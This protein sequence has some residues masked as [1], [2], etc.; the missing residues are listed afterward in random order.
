[1]A[2]GKNCKFQAGSGIDDGFCVSGSDREGPVITIKN[3]DPLNPVKPYT[4][5]TITI[6]TNEASKCKFNLGNAS[7]KFSNM[8]YR[9]GEGFDNR[10]TVVLNF[11][12]Q[13]YEIEGEETQYSIL[14]NGLNFTMYIRCVDISG[15]GE[16]S[17]PISIEIDVMNAPEFN[18]PLLSNFNPVSGSA[19]RYNSTLQAINFKMNEPAECRW[20]FND[21]SFEVMGNNFNCDTAPNSESI[22]NG[23]SCAGI[24]TNVTLELNNQTKYYIKCKDHPEY[25]ADNTTINGVV[26][27][28]NSHTSENDYE[29][30]L[31]PSSPLEITYVSPESTITVNA[32]NSTFALEAYTSGGAGAGT[33]VCFWKIAD[34]IEMNGTS[35]ARFS[36]TNSSRHLHIV[37]NKTSNLYYAQVRCEDVA[38]NMAWRNFSF[39]LILD[40]SGPEILRFY[41][42]AE[43][44]HIYTSEPSTC[45]IGTNREE[46]CFFNFQNATKMSGYGKEHGSSWNYNDYNY[47]ICKDYFGNENAGCAMVIRTY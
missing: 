36:R 33:S 41:N 21:T 15:N 45:A 39:N 28:R 30:I 3:Q 19:I 38:G 46:G 10:H 43:G 17:R 12:G 34:N 23:Y 37:T 40:Y 35:L 29:Y 26:Y 18:A 16:L 9:F 47:I 32:G 42:Y 14:A 31:R 20:S 8:R 6:S 24:L 27:S 22:F 1:M 5:V 11:P 7:A 25:G 4:P 44:L 2:L 13:E